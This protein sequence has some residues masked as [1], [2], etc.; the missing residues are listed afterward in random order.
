[1][2][3]LRGPARRRRLRRELRAWFRHSLLPIPSLYLVAAVALG[4]T[5]PVV[6]RHADTIIGAG[7]GIQSARDVLTS[8][9]TGMI[10]FTGLVVASV[11]VVVQF[12]ASQYSPRLVQ[13]FQ[14]DLVVKHAVG[15]FLAAPLFALVA[16]RELERR[17]VSFSPDVTV[18][19]ALLLLIGAAVLFLALLQRVID[20]LRPRALYGAM[21]REGIRAVRTLYPE[22]LDVPAA[23]GPTPERAGAGAGAGVG[24]RS[25]HPREVVLERHAGVVTAVDRGLLVHAAAAA[26][27]TLELVPAVGEFVGAREPLLRVHGDGAVDTDVLRWAVAVGEERALEQDPE[28]ALRIIV[29][30]AI[31][32]LSPAVND[33]TTA[34]HG[35]DAIEA[36]LREL[37]SRELDASLLRGPDRVVR[38][39]WR[40]PAWEDLLGLACDEIRSYGAG[41]TQICRRLRALLEDLRRVAPPLR[42][43]A[44]DEQLGRLDASIALA[45]P[46]GSPDLTVAL[47]SDRIGIGLSRRG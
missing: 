9:A 1:M 32:A 36:I 6:D 41:S 33:P 16:L 46:A 43:A 19:V 47:G 20:R 10:A 28:F 31:R 3:A 39:V 18:N 34:V 11:L 15:S 17:E 27:V 22:P 13:W 8:T 45:F 2:R 21:A 38:L 5:I 12:A 7:I 29:D 30:T 42:H 25:S 37:A 4:L 35:L 26:G 14:R 40:T 23:A 44:I 24:W